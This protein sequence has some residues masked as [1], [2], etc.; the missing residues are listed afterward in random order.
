MLSHVDDFTLGIVL[1]REV[2]M[3]GGEGD[4]G[5]VTLDVYLG[6]ITIVAHT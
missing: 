4:T 3:I 6:P 5:I 2:E 1:G